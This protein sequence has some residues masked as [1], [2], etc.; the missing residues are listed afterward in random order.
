MDRRPPVRPDRRPA[1][2][3]LIAVAAATASLILSR[4]AWATAYTFSNPNGGA[5]NVSTNFTPVGVPGASDTLVIDDLPRIFTNTTLTLPVNQTVAGITYSHFGQTS[6]N[7]PGV[8]TLANGTLAFNDGITALPDAPLSSLFINASIAGSAGLTKTGPGFAVLAGANTYTGGTTI[9]GA[10]AYSAPRGLT[11]LNDMSLG[12]SG[13]TVTLSNYGTLRAASGFTT[14]RPIVTSNGFGRIESYGA[15]TLNGAVTGAGGLQV[16]GYTGGTVTFGSNINTAN[17]LQILDGNTVN[18]LGAIQ[19]LVLK[20]YGTLN[21]GNATVGANAAALTNTTLMDV[22]GG[23]IRVFA[24]SSSVNAQTASTVYLWSGAS[25]IELD[26]NVNGGAAFTAGGYAR[27]NRATLFVLGRD[28]GNGPAG[29]NRGN[30]F[31]NGTVPA[32]IGGG[33]TTATNTSIISHMLGNANV[34]GGTS[35]I[36]VI[37]AG[38]VT[39]GANGVRPL[40]ANEYAT[41]LGS[42][43][44]DNVR[45]SDGVVTQNAGAT[46]NSLIVRDTM[47]SAGLSGVT[48]TG[49]LTITSG[50]IAAVSDLAGEELFID[51]PIAFGATEGVIHTAPTADGD[52]QLTLRGPISG[53]NGITKAGRGDLYLTNTSSTYTGTTTLDGGAT[54]ITGSVPVS[55]ASVLGAD[56]SAVV[57]SAGSNGNTYTQ[58]LL[59]TPGSIFARNIA[60]ITSVGSVT[61]SQSINTPA[62]IGTR[63]GVGSVISGN[64]GLVE[65]GALTLLGDADPAN[66]FTITGVISGG[67]NPVGTIQDPAVAAPQLQY[68][69]LTGNNFYGDTIIRAG[70][71]QV[72]SNTA[73]GLGTVYFAGNNTTTPTGGIAAFGGARSLANTLVFRAAPVFAGTDALTFTG[74][75]DL[76]S[77]NREVY[78]T[79]TADTT[80]A[81]VVDRGGIIKRG[82]G[83]LILAG[84][85]LYNGQTIAYEGTLRAASNA[86][87]GI[88][89]GTTNPNQGTFII[90]TGVLELANSINTSEA[91]YLGSGGNPIA[92]ANPTGNLRSISGANTISESVSFDN[93]GTVGV[94]GGSTLTLTGDTLDNTANATAALR[95]VGA[96]TLAVKNVRLS[97]LDVQAGTVRITAAG[98]PIGTS[99]VSSLSVA[100]GALL[101][102]TNNSLIYDYTTTSPPSAVIALLAAGQIDTTSGGANGAVGYAEA[103]T[104]FTGATF[105]QSFAGQAFDNTTLILT[106]T[107]AG[108]ATLNKTV[109]FDDL[110]AVAKNYNGTGKVWTQGDFDYN[111]TVDFN[112]LLLL[113]KSYGST[114]PGEASVALAT[115]ASFAADWQLA[116]SLVPEPTTLA[117][118]ILPLV[119]Q[120][121]RRRK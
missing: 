79:N 76:G 110:L 29:A 20:V 81:G 67:N 106:Y 63:G 26:P 90:N 56:S 91:I 121:R 51:N 109:D 100:S 48:G 7:G 82:G 64:I 53:T 11:V 3:L 27:N 99:R 95:K 36:S 49:T 115:S 119:V 24:G 50:A 116:Q 86:A 33:G 104:L 10:G 25:V 78:T 31:I 114:A 65:G 68:I 94:D 55:A 120:T 98:A 85:N 19:N 105:P 44:T 83:R 101:D 60:V 89:A 74:G 15:L 96:G 40:A 84:S 45:V 42:A 62:L 16:A 75:V 57:L 87:L 18:V 13:T 41:T 117:A 34:T 32:L 52:S 38:F 47:A 108:D 21:L 58:L 73:L 1:P 102:L 111:G 72:G 8:L 23:T 9:T 59:D 66:V 113:A 30:F 39:Y 6:I 69:R 103:S 43:A 61:T 88:A 14:S 46:M 35:Q 107:L 93:V 37:D 4:D 77:V 71:W 80:F 2:S 12:A 112:D 22:G 118:M 28:L 5:I 92:S 70:Q 17:G 54:I 97:T